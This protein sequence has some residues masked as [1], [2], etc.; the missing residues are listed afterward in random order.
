MVTL[1]KLLLGS[2]ARAEEDGAVALIA[3][4]TS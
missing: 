3:L 4:E 1:E 2:I